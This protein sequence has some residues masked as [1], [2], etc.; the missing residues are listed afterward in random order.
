MNEW[1]N[2]EI[3]FLKDNYLSMTDKELAQLLNKTEYG[4]QYKRLKLKLIK[5]RIK[6]LIEEKVG[7]LTIIRDTGKKDKSGCVIWECISDNGETIEIPSRL[8]KEGQSKLLKG[9]P[10]DIR[11]GRSKERLY[12]VWKNMRHKCD[13]PTNSSYEYYGA[14]GITY[15]SEWK[16]Y[17]IFKKWAYENGYDEDHERKDCTLDRIDFNGNYCPENCRWVDSHIQSCNR[18]NYGKLPYYGLSKDGNRYKMTITVNSEKIVLGCTTNKDEIPYLIQ[19]RNDY[20]D[21]HNLSNMKN[22]YDPNLEII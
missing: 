22:V 21:Q 3:Q 20:I 6:N 9:I 12:E 11:D 15:C 10:Q 5:P 2:D 1:T 13:N 17:N 14:R 8:L 7:V 16:D 4:I 18:R 19:L